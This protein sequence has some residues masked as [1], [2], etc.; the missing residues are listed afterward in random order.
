MSCHHLVQ[1]ANFGK[2]LTG[3][4]EPYVRTPSVLLIR[5]F[6]GTKFRTFDLTRR[7]ASYE[8]AAITTQLPRIQC[9]GLTFAPKGVGEMEGRLAISKIPHFIHNTNHNK[10]QSTNIQSSFSSRPLHTITMY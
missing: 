6:N 7:S 10:I 8:F 2:W 9:K 1:K 3:N 4:G 5:I